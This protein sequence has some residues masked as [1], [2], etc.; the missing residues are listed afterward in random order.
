MRIA[1]CA[2]TENTKPNDTKTNVVYTYGM[3]KYSLY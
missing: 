3:K 1:D 2:K